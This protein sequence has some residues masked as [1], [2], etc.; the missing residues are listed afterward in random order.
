[1]ERNANPETHTNALTPTKRLKQKEP[2]QAPHEPY[3]NRSS[4]RIHL[5]R[6]SPQPQHPYAFLP[7]A[8]MQPLQGP[9]LSST[10]PQRSL[11]P[12]KQTPKPRSV[13]MAHEAVHYISQGRLRHTATPTPTK[14]PALYSS[15]TTCAH[16]AL[17]E[18]SNHFRTQDSVLH[19][20]TP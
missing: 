14:K 19:D 20:Q 11:K 18:S 3:K 4:N 2:V 15:S 5:P 13:L 8:L 9:L 1:M 17:V 12:P 10:R 7:Q 6:H 16:S